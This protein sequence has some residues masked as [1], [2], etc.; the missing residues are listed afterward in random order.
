MDRLKRDNLVAISPSVSASF[1]PIAIYGYSGEERTWEM[2]KT[3][4]HPCT[5]NWFGASPTETLAFRRA[6]SERRAAGDIVPIGVG[7][8]R[9]L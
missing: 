7:F 1:P 9:P 6:G 8:E 4:S 5:R 3:G 2:I